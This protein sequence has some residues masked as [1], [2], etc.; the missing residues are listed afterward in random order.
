MLTYP[1]GA[2]LACL[3]LMAATATRGQALPWPS[4]LSDQDSQ[5]GLAAA[6]G[7][8]V[9][10]LH[11]VQAALRERPPRDVAAAFTAGNLQKQLEGIPPLLTIKQIGPAVAAVPIL[12]SD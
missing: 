9:E 1:R 4:E 5:I 11:E 6:F 10:G 3:V 2:L 12:K 8:D 7:G